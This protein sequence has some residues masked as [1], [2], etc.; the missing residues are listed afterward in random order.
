MNDFTHSRIRIAFLLGS[1]MFSLI[2]CGGNYSNPEV[3]PLPSVKQFAIVANN[4]DNSLSLFTTDATT[5]QLQANGSVPSG[6]TAPNSIASDPAGKFLYVTNN[7][8]NSV[9]GFTVDAMS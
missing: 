9:S 7:V 6:G 4:A 2:G 3:T 1:L 8:S 5:G